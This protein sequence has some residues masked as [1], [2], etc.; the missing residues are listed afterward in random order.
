MAKVSDICNQ[1]ELAPG[2]A[3]HSKSKVYISYSKR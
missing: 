1:H 2:L 3:R